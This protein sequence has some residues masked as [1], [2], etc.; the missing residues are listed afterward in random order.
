MSVIFIFLKQR[1]TRLDRQKKYR[2]ACFQIEII[3]CRLQEHYTVL[4][5]L[6]T[7]IWNEMNGVID[8]PAKLG[9]LNLL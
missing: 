3:L 2:F 6:T 7:V 1:E 4:A 8:Q 5:S 9:L